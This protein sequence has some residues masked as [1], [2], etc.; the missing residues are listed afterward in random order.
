MQ[1]LINEIEL[2][3]HD[4]KSSV[5]VLE[6]QLIDLNNDIEFKEAALKKLADLLLQ[7]AEH[8]NELKF[9]LNKERQNTVG[10]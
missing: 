9:H 1:D 2:N 7:K 3:N 8:E 10:F 4:L 6:E 5:K